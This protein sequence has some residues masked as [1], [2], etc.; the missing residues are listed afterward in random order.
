MIPFW[1]RSLLARLISSFLLLS[2]V[3]TG[4][5]G[6]VAFIQATNTLEQSVVER[7]TIAA[8]AHQ[9][10]LNLWINTQANDLA[11]VARWE[12]LLEL[13]STIMTTKTVSLEYQVAYTRVSETLRDIVVRR[14]DFNEL[15]ILN[16]EGIVV[17][18]SQRMNKGADYH[19]SQYYLSG[20]TQ[21]FIQ[22]VYANPTTSEPTMT[23]AM[24]L[25]DSLGR[26][27]GVLAV[28]LNLER[29]DTIILDRAGLGET[30]ETYLIDAM[31]EVVSTQNYGQ[32][33]DTSPAF[34]EGINRALAGESGTGH[35]INHLGVPVIGAYTW[36]DRLE[37]ALLVEIEQ[38]E[39]LAPIKQL[40]LNIILAG[41]ITA[42]IL[43]IG[44]YI[45]ARQIARPILQL[46]DIAKEVA[47]GNLKITA[48]VATQDEIG[49][50]AQVFNQMTTQLRQLYEHMEQQVH[51]RTEELRQAKEEAEKAKEEA[52][53]ANRAKSTFL[54]NMSHELRTPLSAIIGFVQLMRQDTKTTP[55]QHEYLQ[56]VQRNSQH[57]RNLIN[58]VLEMSKIEAGRTTLNEHA[59]NFHELL[60]DIDAMFQMQAQ[61]KG[62]DLLIDYKDDVPQSIYTDEQKLRQVLINLI[63]NAI[64]FTQKGSVTVCV[65]IQVVE[66]DVSDV[67]DVSDEQTL[68]T[69]ATP[70]QRLT[71][72]VIDTGPGIA[73]DELHNLFEVF[74][75][76]RTGQQ[77]QEGTGLGLAICRS[78]AQLMGG[79]LTVQ[80]EVELGTTVTFTIPVARPEVSSEEEP[81]DTQQMLK[82][83]PGQPTYRVLVVDD[84]PDNRHLL[85]KMLAR[86]GFDV[87][88][89]CDG[90]EAIV[91]W[92]RW[93]PHLIWMDI[94]MPVMD[95]Y[96]ATRRIKAK[97]NG[98]STTIVALTASA[99]EEER[100]HILEAGCDDFVGKP[101]CDSDILECM[102][103]HLG[104]AYHSSEISEVQA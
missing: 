75:Q 37:L 99:F 4:V 55:T 8:Q 87:Q 25:L 69:P 23:I 82:L 66:S 103:K 40:A 71:V 56:I 60:S 15:F 34:S 90:Q 58:D 67:S 52:E 41:I 49:V 70:T 42:S 64:K 57:L 59:F 10:E 62:I 104:V 13:T 43:G 85:A 72:E 68:S 102:T 81:L 28:H 9:D 76:T 78:F 5:A 2:L 24:P 92:E 65:G 88:E 45:L 3:M 96:E 50:L 48:P 73:P 22:N 79:T 39:A 38:Q 35:Y 80:S 20:R 14:P 89:A 30:G 47:T 94:R 32:Q 46:T 63:S 97:T 51:A 12:E 33:D 29:M 91:V 16:N 61:E 6:V 93:K 18:S 100:N 19:E 54:A 26:R 101:F 1:N 77:S 17:V 95:G 84:L 44:V 31:A 36:L 74:V 7:L 21:T 83:A 53:K 27:M 11:F 86:V 98:Q